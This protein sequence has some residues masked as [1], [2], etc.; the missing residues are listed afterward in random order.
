[1]PK[2]PQ[3]PNSYD[4]ASDAVLDRVDK[5]I[6]L[7]HTALKA[8]RVDVITRTQAAKKN[9]QPIV[10]CAK[11]V[12]GINAHMAGSADSFFVIEI[13]E[14]LLTQLDGKHQDAVLDHC[15]ERC[16]VIGDKLSLREYDVQE[17]TAVVH[18]HGLY[19][20]RLSDL[21]KVGAKQ[22][23]LELE[24]GGAADPHDDPDPDDEQETDA[25]AEE[26]AAGG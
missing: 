10:A 3:E 14:R 2:E 4:T 8:V 16:L 26:A 19:N 15:L 25:F 6:D 12:T 18:R 21:V 13:C 7:H 22:M 20:G 1:M 5:L 11:L 9:G 17:F 23:T 24:E